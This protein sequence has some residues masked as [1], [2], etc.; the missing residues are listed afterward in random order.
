MS[1]RLG[2]QALARR[3]VN[4]FPEPEYRYVATVQPTPH[5]A[6]FV[7]TDRGCFNQLQEGGQI[8]SLTIYHR[9]SDEVICQIFANLTFGLRLYVV[10]KYLNKGFDL[11]RRPKTIAFGNQHQ[12]RLLLSNKPK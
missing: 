1:Y 11:Y 6:Q 2:F 10:S 3:F 7:Y 4:R 12:R 8:Q 5:Q 9:Q